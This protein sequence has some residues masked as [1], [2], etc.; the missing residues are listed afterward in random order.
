MRFFYYYPTHDKPSG[1]NKE[2]RLHASLLREL[3]VEVFLL[4]DERHFTGPDPFDDDV[5]Y[6]V[7]VEVAPVPFERAAG[8][9]KPDDVVV[10]PEVLLSDSL[11]RCA[12]W[13]CRVAVNNQNG[14]YG[15]RYGPPRALARKRIEFVMAISPYV[16]ALSRHF[17]G[18]PRNRIF[19]VSPWIVRPPFEISEPSAESA[20]AVSYMPRKMPDLVRQIREAVQHTHPDVPWVEIDSV[21]EQEVARRLRANRV[22][23]VAQDLEGCPLTALEAMTCNAIVAG[24]PGTA[25]FPHPYAT[26]ENGFWVRDRDAKAAA[27]AVGRAIDLAR[28]GGE[29]Y[30][31]MLEAGHATARRYNR[32]SVLEGLREVATTVAK[33]AYADRTGPQASLGSRGWLQAARL[34]YDADKLG[35][36]GRIAGKVAGAAKRMG[37]K[38]SAAPVE[39]PGAAS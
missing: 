5:F 23:F 25:R 2:L 16:A 29:P 31:K 22:F 3:D 9:L 10:L 19:H 4:R 21:P 14:F 36:L 38:R 20:L 7:P 11:A 1:G 27:V 18:V 26:A 24:F 30:R 35:T 32:E 37:K 28:A 8:H 39:K 6:R 13:N 34:L 17:Y 33:R 15:L 12:T